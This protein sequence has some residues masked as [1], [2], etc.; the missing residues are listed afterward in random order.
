MFRVYLFVNWMS[1]IEKNR[2]KFRRIFDNN[3]LLGSLGIICNRVCLTNFRLGDEKINNMIEIL[4]VS[5]FG[6]TGVNLREHF[7]WFYL[8]IWREWCFVSVAVVV[9]MAFV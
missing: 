9:C 7:I 4:C 6:D 1:F 2:G 8:N 3:S 5:V